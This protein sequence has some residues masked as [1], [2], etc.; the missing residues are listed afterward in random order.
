MYTHARLLRS[1]D[2]VVDDAERLSLSSYEVLYKLT[3]VRGGR[4]RMKDIGS[5]LLVSKSGLTR[6]VDELEKRGYVAR[7][8][9]PT[10]ARGFDIVLTASGRRAYRRAEQA[11]LRQL[12]SAFLGRLSD[13]QL[14]ALADIWET[15]ELCGPAD[16]TSTPI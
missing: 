13:T 15:A 1:L 5:T 10:D 3:E 16:N 11:F 12:R 7:E 14:A 9:C 2:E 8:R 6:V 4:I